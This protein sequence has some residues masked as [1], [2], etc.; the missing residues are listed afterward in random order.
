MRVKQAIASYCDE[1]A[2]SCNRNLKV[3]QD[4][5]PVCFSDPPAH[6]NSGPLAGILAAIQRFPSHDLLLSPCDAPL[7]TEMYAQRMLAGNAAKAIATATASATTIVSATTTARYAETDKNRHY[8]HCFIP[9]N[10]A[11]TLDDYL[12][13][14][15]R[16]MKGWLASLQAEPVNFNDYGWMFTNI[17]DEEGLASA[18]QIQQMKGSA[19]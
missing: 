2:I 12:A 7:L 9:A 18:N 11:G 1:V 6:R 19:R 17:N 14:G 4:I 13:S 10:Q 3:Y 8:L 16:S 15:Q 5:C